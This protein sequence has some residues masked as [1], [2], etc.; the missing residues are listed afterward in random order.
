[1]IAKH[2]VLGKGVLPWLVVLAL[3]F[4]MFA[5]V[6]AYLIYLNYQGPQAQ[7]AEANGHEYHQPNGIFTCRYSDNWHLDSDLA[8]TGTPGVTLADGVGNFIE[9][10]YYP[11]DKYFGVV[12]SSNRRFATADDY[13]QW[14]KQV[15]LLDSVA[16]YSPL[17]PVN[18]K[19][20]RASEFSVSYRRN[21]PVTEGV[22]IPDGKGRVRIGTPAKT[23]HVVEDMV[24]I[25]LAHGL[26]VAKLSASPDL[27]PDYHADFR[28]IL[29]SLEIS[30]SG[31]PA[32]KGL[33]KA[34]TFPK[35]AAR[36]Y[37]E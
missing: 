9:L 36:G 3:L 16:V 8:P 27:Y 30:D 20:Q 19:Q 2:R 18:W 33:P 6:T 23:I 14:Y 25:P 32:K 10:R 31:L 1:M 11:A 21:F 4:L 29:N 7:A 35:F 22:A 24:V 26:F 17:I 37:A 28:A 15:V 13:Y 34:P 12:P 5:G